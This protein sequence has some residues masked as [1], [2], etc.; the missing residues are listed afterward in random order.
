MPGL[1]NY[2][3]WISTDAGLLIADILGDST[4]ILADGPR[5]IR[6]A[7]DDGRRR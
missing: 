6:Q 2:T 7:P 5:A 4:E 3:R 1:R